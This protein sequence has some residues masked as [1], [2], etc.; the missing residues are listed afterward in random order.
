M[1]R[2][3]L[4]VSNIAWEREYDNQIYQTM[5]EMGF[6]GLEIAP[7][8]IFPDHPYEHL[9]EARGWAESL[10]EEYNLR[11]P[12]MQS[13]WRGVRNKLFG[14]EEDT[15]YLIDYTKQAIDFASCI[16]CGNLVF[17]CPINRCIPKMVSRE[18]AED[19]A[20]V[21]FGLVGSYAAEKG[22]V[23][24]LEANPIIYDTNFINTTMDAIGF[25]Q[26]VNSK[27]LKLNLDLGTVIYN[28][29]DIMWIKDY[30]YLINHL[31]ISEPYLKPIK[32]REIHYVLRDLLKDR[33][34]GFISIELGNGEDINTVKRSMKYISGVFQ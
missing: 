21:F 5:S 24:G 3:N 29:E 9:S 25:I 17:G 26:K 19:R 18:E 1:Y 27:G 28:E 11:V 14:S 34:R 32:E 10:K 22:T 31:H 15:K 2:Y 23:I 13:I 4:S 20:I 6:S 12:S 16:N 30:V 8:R 7:T 33:Y